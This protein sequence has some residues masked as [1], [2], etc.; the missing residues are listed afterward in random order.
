MKSG[1]V[2]FL[3]TVTLFGVLTVPVDLAAHNANSE[4]IT[5]EAPGAGTGANQGTGCFGCTF[6]LNQRGAIAGTYLDANNVYHGFVR[7]PE[8]RSSEGKFT[9]FEAPGADTTPGSYNGTT[10]QSINDWGEITGYYADATGVAHGFVRSPWGAFTTFDVPGAA[11]GSFPVFINLE[12]AVVGY[13]WDA[14][15][16]FHAFL[17]RPDGTFAV[18]VGPESCTS[19]TPAGCYGSEATYVDLVGRSVGNFEDNSGNFVGHGLLRSSGGKLTT[20]DAPGAGTGLYQGTG[21]PG[22]NLG[23]NHWG[24]IAGTY[25]DANNVFHGFLRS[26]EGKFTTFEAPGADTTPG[27]YNGTGCFSD[28]P[29]GLNDWGVITGSYWDSNNVQHGFLRTPDGSFVTVDPP[30]SA[31]TQPE[32]INDSGAITGYYLDANN[33]YH[34]FLRAQ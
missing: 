31:G 10:A 34:G 14:N 22:C 30:G 13:S 24:A 6:G 33:V 25:T 18:F 4:M 9:T 20:F 27:S 16:L 11:N 15:L 17:R 23:V 28:C 2:T 3:S 32:S 12:G 29:V 7:S 5:F 26:S 8:G 21:C 19:G 1:R